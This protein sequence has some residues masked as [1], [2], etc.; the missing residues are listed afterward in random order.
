MW[1]HRKNQSDLGLV[2]F[3]KVGAIEKW[4]KL[5]LVPSNC[6]IYLGL[7]SIRKVGAFKKSNQFRVGVF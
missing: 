5:G 2:S 1:C 6:Q 3:R 4:N 7:V